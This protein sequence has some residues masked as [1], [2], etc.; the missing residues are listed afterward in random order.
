MVL[1]TGNVDGAEQ[2]RDRMDNFQ[3]GNCKNAT[4]SPRLI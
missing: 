3:R 2:M 4:M 1:A